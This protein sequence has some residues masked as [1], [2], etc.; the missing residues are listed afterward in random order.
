MLELYSIYRKLPR[1]ERK[2][3]NE[4]GGRH[5]AGVKKLRNPYACAIKKEKR[6]KLDSTNNRAMHEDASVLW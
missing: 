1:G 3:E 5:E 2:R 6:N 4:C